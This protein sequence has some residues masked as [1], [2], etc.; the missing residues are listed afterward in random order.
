MKCDKFS[1]GNL[2]NFHLNFNKS[3]TNLI[4]K[5]LPNFHNKFYQICTTDL[6]YF[7]MK[8]NNFRKKFNKFSQE[9]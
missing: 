9:F 6:T 5:M 8:F 3:F 2:I 7:H 4:F 1:A